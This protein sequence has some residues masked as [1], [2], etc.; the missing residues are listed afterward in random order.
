M[1]LGGRPPRRCRPP[2]LRPPLETGVTPRAFLQAR[3][4]PRKHTCHSGTYR[5]VTG[6][7][8]GGQWL[9]LPQGGGERPRYKLNSK[10]RKKNKN[11]ERT[12]TGF[13][14]FR[15]RFRVGNVLFRRGWPAGEEAGPCLSLMLSDRCGRATGTV[16]VRGAA[17]PPTSVAGPSL[18]SSWKHF[19][20][21]PAAHGP[22]GPNVRPRPG[23]KGGL[24]ASQAKEARP[25]HRPAPP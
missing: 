19:D 16:A 20:F 12:S 9:C 15:R 14:A 1:S 13:F 18:R 11:E 23:G 2:R 10:Q 6:G 17:S 3:G 8:F 25:G 21:P 7:T 4:R 24:S 5:P 22:N